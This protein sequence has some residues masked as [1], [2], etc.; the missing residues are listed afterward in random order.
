MTVSPHNLRGVL[1]YRGY[2]ETAAQKR[3][4]A[5]LRDVVAAAPMFHPETRRGK[6]MSVRMTSAGRFGWISDRRGYRYEPRHP[7][8]ADWPPIPP[9]VLD[10]WRELVTDSSDP[11]CC[12]VNYYG[13]GARM[14][15]HQDRDEADFSWPVL[16]I[17]LG[18]EGLFRVGNIERGG[19]TESLWLQSGDVLV[20]GGAARLVHHGVD[21]IRFGSS[22]LLP[23]HGRLNLTCRV[24]T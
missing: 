3:L 2:L 14:G 23:K 20:M 5:A 11:D 21:R 15:L 22:S 1:L 9:Q 16:S 13:E 6:Q 17:S 4:V 7:S 10:V 19:S 24:V 18:D 8:G 12:L